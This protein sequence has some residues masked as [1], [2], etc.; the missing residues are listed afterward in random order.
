MKNVF[1]EQIIRREFHVPICAVKRLSDSGAICSEEA[2]CN[3]IPIEHHLFRALTIFETSREMPE[4]ELFH[5]IH[6]HQIGK[7]VSHCQ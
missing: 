5:L 1:L 6:T 2:L 3:S 7:E 4:I